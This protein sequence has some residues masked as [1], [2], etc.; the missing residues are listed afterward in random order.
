MLV[1]FVAAVPVAAANPTVSFVN[2]IPGR[3]VDVCVGSNE[4]G[5]GIGYGKHFRSSVGAGSKV[6]SFRVAGS[7]KCQGAVLAQQTVSLVADQAYT[8]VGTSDTPKK[9]TVFSNPAG[10]SY[11]LRY[12]G[13]LGQVGFSHQAATWVTPAVLTFFTKGVGVETLIATDTLSVL[14]AYTPGNAQPFEQTKI[15]LTQEGFRTEI[16]LVGSTK[17]NAKFVVLRHSAT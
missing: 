15:V 4:K 3:S 17:K 13:D 11:A 6:I 12:A 9:V 5:S 10:S 8:I 14:A 7:G 16:I 2:G 1:P